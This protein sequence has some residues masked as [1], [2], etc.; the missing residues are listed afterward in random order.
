ML[1]KPG[2][3]IKVAAIATDTSG[4]RGPPLTTLVPITLDTPPTALVVVPAASLTPI[5]GEHVD[6]TVSAG[7]DV[8]VAQVSFKAQTGKPVDAATRAVVPSVKTRSEA[9]GF[10]VPLDAIP[11]SSIAVQGSVT[12]TKG[13]VVDATPVI[14][15]VRDAVAPTVKITGATS[16]TQVRPGQQTTVIVTVQDAGLIRSITF[17]AAGVAALTQTRVIDPPQILHRHVV[18]GVGARGRQA[19]AEPDPGRDGRGSRRQRRQRRAGDPAGRR[20]RRAND[21]R[22]AHR[23]GPAAD[24]PRPQ[25]HGAGRGRGRPRRL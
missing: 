16:G 7:D 21:H 3:L 5:N 11:G 19:A 4:R 18:C 25:R 15:T 8:G 9:F 2:D 23:F 10:I 24:R 22:D 12:D 6:V 14:V 20:Q 13:Q 1:G 17:K